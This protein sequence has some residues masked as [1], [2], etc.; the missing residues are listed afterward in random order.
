[1]NENFRILI[2]ISLRIVPKGLIDKKV[3]FVQ[4][5]TWHQTHDKPLPEPML[6][7]FTGTHMRH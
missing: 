4:V 7:Q 2:Q 6:I 5:M 3:A 1:M